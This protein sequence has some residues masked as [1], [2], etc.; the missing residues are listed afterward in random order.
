MSA[1]SIMHGR[2]GG[3]FE[4]EGG[5]CVFIDFGNWHSTF[6]SLACAKEHVQSVLAQYP[7][8]SLVAVTI[9]KEGDA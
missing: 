6:L 8:G 5:V 2:V 3:A 1:K 9:E 4:V 7:K